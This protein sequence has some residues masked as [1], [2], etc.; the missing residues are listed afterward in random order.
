[1]V[2]PPAHREVAPALP[3]VFGAYE[4]VEALGSGGSG[5]AYLAVHSESDELVVVKCLHERL[6]GT[7]AFIRRFRHEAVLAVEIDSP[8]VAACYDVGTLDGVPYIVME[9]LDGWSVSKTLDVHRKAKRH[10]T[11]ETALG[12][13]LDLLNGLDDLHGAVNRRTNETLG[14][15]HRDIKPGNLMVEPSGRLRIIDLGLGK[16]TLQDW[17]TRTGAVMGS[18]GYMAPE[19]VLANEVDH[20]AD[21]YAAAVVAFELL[22]LERLVARG[23]PAEMLQRCAS[24]DFRPPSSLRPEVPRA[25]D[26]VLARALSFDPDE[27][28]QSAGQLARAFL[29]AVGRRRNDFDVDLS[30]LATPERL[31]ALEATKVRIEGRDATAS[32]TDDTTTFVFASKPITKT[33]TAPDI[34]APRSS[35][36]YAVWAALLVVV[37]SATALLTLFVLDGAR[38]V[39][40]PTS[41]APVPAQRPTAPVVAPRTTPVEEET[42]PR[43]KRPARRVRRRVERRS[44]P[45]PPETPPPVAPLPTKVTV[46]RLSALA[47]TI[48]ARRPDRAKEIDAVLGDVTMW[49]GNEDSERAQRALRR[50]EARLRAVER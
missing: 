34:E 49:A 22:T 15:V 3:A 8:H 7:D 18:P 13:T 4:L 39:S 23:S 42:R 21:L 32:H 28:Y 31:E 17:K 30:L 40:E 47:Q 25:L 36:P 6:G 20:R 45:P 9:Y 43:V 24:P 19:Q 16:S 1:M 33:A 46:A 11:V 38:F 10:L 50:L 48:R 27:R 12:L 2:S 41:I 5:T 37:T 26:D 29:S 14:F 35:P 44:P